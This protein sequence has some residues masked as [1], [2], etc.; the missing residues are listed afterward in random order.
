MEML[1]LKSMMKKKIHNLNLYNNG[2]FSNNCGHLSD[3]IVDQSD[4]GLETILAHEDYDI[5]VNSFSEMFDSD[6]VKQLQDKNFQWHSVLKGEPGSRVIQPGCF[7]KQLNEFESSLDA[8][9]RIVNN[10]DWE[11]EKF[12]CASSIPYK[13]RAHCWDREY[14]SFST[15]CHGYH[16]L[17]LKTD[18]YCHLPNE[19]NWILPPHGQ[20]NPT[21]FMRSAGFDIGEYWMDFRSQTLSF[22]TFGVNCTGK[23]QSPVLENVYDDQIANDH[24]KF[25]KVREQF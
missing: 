1:N 2:L 23:E 18:N 11:M 8:R 12:C 10:T 7:P 20:K 22:L 4:E 17:T 19:V 9:I 15:C 24:L 5:Q 16:Q 6:F 14:K 25:F 21:G 13:D 3:D